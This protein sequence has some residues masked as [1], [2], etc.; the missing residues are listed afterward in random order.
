MSNQTINLTFQVYL[1]VYVPAVMFANYMMESC[2]L[3]LSLLVAVILNSAGA[4]LRLLIS[5]E[6]AFLWAIIG[7]LIAGIANPFVLSAPPKI[8]VLWF[9]KEQVRYLLD[10]AKCSHCS[11]K[12]DLST[13]CCLFLHSSFPLSQ[14]C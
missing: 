8:S 5:V 11:W 12:Y 10:L 7:Q 6:D 4:W 14:R 9:P 2:G 3:Y 1:F 13:R